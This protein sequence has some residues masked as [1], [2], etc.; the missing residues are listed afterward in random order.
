MPQA[1]YLTKR[2]GYMPD[3]RSSCREQKNPIAATRSEI[4]IAFTTE[5]TQRISH[6]LLSIFSML[7]QHSCLYP[8]QKPEFDLYLIPRNA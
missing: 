6:A 1:E 4:C 3:F 8:K 7:E 5:R 2:A